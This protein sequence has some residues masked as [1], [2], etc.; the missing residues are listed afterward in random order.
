MNVKVNDP[1]RIVHDPVV[2]FLGTKGGYMTTPDGHP[3]AFGLS[4][5]SSAGRETLPN[6]TVPN[7]L[8]KETDVSIP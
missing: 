3:K 8:N 4:L 7:R 2:S 6:R 1:G 5:P